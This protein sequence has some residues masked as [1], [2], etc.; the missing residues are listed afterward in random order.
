MSFLRFVIMKLISIGQLLSSIVLLSLMVGCA[1]TDMHTQTIPDTH[2]REAL[3]RSDPAQ[4]TLPALGTPEEMKML[5]AVKALFVEYT[6]DN[7]SENI[8]NVY[9]DEVYF[10]D[11]FKQLSTAREIRE[12]MLAGLEPL[13]GAEFVFTNVARTGGDFYLEWTMR[14]NFKKTPA[15]TWEESIGVSRM[16]FNSE[17]KVIFHQDYWDPTDIVY[18]RI[19]IAKQ[20]IA[21][22]K[23]K[24]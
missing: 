7:L 22:V 9:A 13:K 2:Y 11:A 23:K 3:V 4:F 19:P 20:L 18:K 10:R 6:H 5:N 14:L 16:R 24:L 15:D 17:G 12:Y 21:Y 8:E 1:S